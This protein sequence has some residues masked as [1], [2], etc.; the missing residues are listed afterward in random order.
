MNQMPTH[1][2]ED[3]ADGIAQLIEEAVEKLDI[4]KE[5]LET[6]DEWSNEASHLRRDANLLRKRIVTLREALAMVLLAKECTD[7]QPHQIPSVD[8]Y[9]AG[10][11]A[12]MV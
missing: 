4:A 2:L 11:R 8:A 5:R 1:Y 3:P 12:E 6:E 9:M 10:R 7:G